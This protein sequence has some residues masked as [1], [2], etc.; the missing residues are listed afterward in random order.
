MSG[1]S[2]PYEPPLVEDLQADGPTATA[3]GN[4]LPYTSITLVDPSGK[5]RMRKRW[6]RREKTRESGT[7]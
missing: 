5:R 6:R 2:R 3:A 1:D 7:D 4:S